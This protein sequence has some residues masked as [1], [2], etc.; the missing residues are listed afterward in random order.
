MNAL[1][2]RLD[3][4]SQW[5]TKEGIEK[6]TANYH[7]GLM[8]IEKDF[9]EYLEYKKNGDLETETINKTK[10]ITWVSIKNASTEELFQTKLEIFESTPVQESDNK[11]YRSNIRKASSI[12][13]A[14]YWYY[15]IVDKS[16]EVAGQ[17]LAPRGELPENIDTLLEDIHSDA[18]LKYKLQIFEREN[19]KY[20]ENKKAKAEIRKANNLV[21]LFAA[22]AE[23]IA[24][25]EKE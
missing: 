1:I 23:L 6:S 5:K 12:V 16:D 4:D 24:S 3:D 18:I 8:Q 7:N 2:D 10:P 22:Y 13:E 20:S 21:E 9:D 17:G 15:L 25:E 19:V 11:T 14:M